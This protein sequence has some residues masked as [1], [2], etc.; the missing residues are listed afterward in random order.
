MNGIDGA[1]LDDDEKRRMRSAFERE[2]DE[3]DSQLDMPAGR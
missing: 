2:L 1:W 3:L